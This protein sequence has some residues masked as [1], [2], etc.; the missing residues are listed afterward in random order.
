MEIEH[1]SR[2]HVEIIFA[3][4]VELVERMPNRSDI[5][6]SHVIERD[7]IEDLFRGWK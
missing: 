5:Y 2:S 3:P 1:N 6:R 4:N 7:V